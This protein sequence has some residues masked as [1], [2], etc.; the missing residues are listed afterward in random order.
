MQPD[1]LGGVSASDRER[2]L[3]TGSNCTLIARDWG[4]GF[5][6]LVQGDPAASA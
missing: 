3:V 6:A 5:P 4:A 2:P 1:L